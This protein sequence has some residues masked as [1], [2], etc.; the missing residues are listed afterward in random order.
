MQLRCSI[1]LLI[2][3]LCRFFATNSE[4][5]FWIFLIQKRLYRFFVQSMCFFA[6]KCWHVVSHGYFFHKAST[7]ARWGTIFMFL[8]FLSQKKFKF[9]FW[10]RLTGKGTSEVTSGTSGYHLL[11]TSATKKKVGPSWSGDVWNQKK[12]PR[13]WWR[14]RPKN[15]LGG[16]S[17]DADCLNCW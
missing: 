14:L 11:V 10:I 3:L 13:L 5:C 2:L 7:K 12:S 8:R 9:F 16:A 1:Q 17:L 6:A 4:K 15:R